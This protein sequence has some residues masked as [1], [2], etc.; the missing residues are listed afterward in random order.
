MG[1]D[2]AISKPPGL[3]A[4]LNPSFVLQA[5]PWPGGAS[6]LRLHYQAV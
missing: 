4:A 1:P 2:Y 5:D 6:A 3:L